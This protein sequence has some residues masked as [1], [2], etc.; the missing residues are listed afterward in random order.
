MKNALIFCGIIVLIYVVYRV[1]KYQTLDDGLDKLIKNRA[2]ILD[3]RTEKEYETGHIAGSQNISLGT[4]RERY[5]ELDPNKTYITV[6]SHGLRSVKVEHILKEKGF[7]NV[8]NG[9]AWSDLQKS[10]NLKISENK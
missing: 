2:V 1:Y 3:V 5:V 4:I 8:H 9:G 6:C 10:F 7:K